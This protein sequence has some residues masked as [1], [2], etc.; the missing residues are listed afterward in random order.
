MSTVSKSKRGDSGRSNA[1][2]S[3]YRLNG[4]VP[5]WQARKAGVHHVGP[6]ASSGRKTLQGLMEGVWAEALGLRW[7]GAD[8]LYERM[9]EHAE[10]RTT[11]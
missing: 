3:P 1:A 11:K 9:V 4:F 7:R 5:D 6:S 8:P 10:G 2:N